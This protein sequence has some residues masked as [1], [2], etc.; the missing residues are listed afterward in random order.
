MI[1]GGLDFMDRLLETLAVAE[2][3]DELH[4]ATHRIEGRYPEHVGIVKVENAFI[5]VFG[6]QR[7]EDGTRLLAILRK[8]V[9]LL[10]VLGALAAG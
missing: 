7:T 5:G 4:D 8:K 1:E 6:E 10:D 3:P 2:C 9:A